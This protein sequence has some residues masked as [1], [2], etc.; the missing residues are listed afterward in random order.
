[1]TK[2]NLELKII[3]QTINNK[4]NMETK[5]IIIIFKRVKAKSNKNVMLFILIIFINI[6]QLINAKTKYTI[7]ITIQGKGKQQI[8]ENEH[9]EF[10]YTPSEIYVNGVLQNYTGFYVYD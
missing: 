3:N 2:K 9:Y 4:P 1:M 7:L 6:L 8:L 5:N 10:N